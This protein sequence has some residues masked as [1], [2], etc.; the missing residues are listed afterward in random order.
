MSVQVL[1]GNESPIYQKSNENY[2]STEF[3]WLRYSENLKKGWVLSC[4]S[5]KIKSTHLQKISGL[6]KLDKFRNNILKE[7]L[8]NPSEENYS[9][10]MDVLEL[11]LEEHFPNI[12]DFDKWG[13]EGDEYSPWNN[14][15]SELETITK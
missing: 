10:H 6:V 5:G 9:F 11:L 3:R 13:L 8:K 1:W 7:L 4:E 14:P 2:N 15:F 12:K